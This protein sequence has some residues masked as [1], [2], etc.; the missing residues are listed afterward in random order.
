MD[1]KR[2]SRESGALWQCSFSASVNIL[3]MLATTKV[4]PPSATSGAAAAVA[5]SSSD[6]NSWNCAEAS[7]RMILATSL[8]SW[9]LAAAFALLSSPSATFTR[10]ESLASSAASGGVFLSRCL[11]A[12]N[13]RAS[14]MSPAAPSAAAPSFSMISCAASWEMPST[15]SGASGAAASW[16]FLTAS[17]AAAT[18]AM[19]SCC[20]ATALRSC[21]SVLNCS[22]FSS[23]SAFL[24]T[25]AAI[26]SMPA[27]AAA[28][29]SD[30]ISRDLEARKALAS[31]IA[32]CT[33]AAAAS[34]SARALAA[35]S[36]GRISMPFR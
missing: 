35:S 33:A 30:F 19:A 5:F 24:F 32:C 20:S 25:S 26:S 10:P 21:V 2:S 17:S 27:W 18:L 12:R 36:V 15:R 1:L 16:V 29:R 3:V 34:E 4:L 6:S 22:S 9:S 28:S 31:A 7:C 23:A 8:C 14:A 11:S 13:C